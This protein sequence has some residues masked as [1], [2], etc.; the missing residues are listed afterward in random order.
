MGSLPIHILKRPSNV[1]W[2]FLDLLSM[3]QSAVAGVNSIL[4]THRKGAV[5]KKEDEVLPVSHARLICSYGVSCWNYTYYSIPTRY[6]Y[7]VV[8]S[9]LDWL[10]ACSFPP[11]F[12]RPFCAQHL[13]SP[14]P[15][16]YL[17]RLQLNVSSTAKLWMFS[18]ARQFFKTMFWWW[19]N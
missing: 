9:H 11:K 5:H 2:A 13:Y 16:Y 4:G 1:E 19:P 17:L 12:Y 3:R 18:T 14:F 8:Y 10:S 6:I 15:K 7:P